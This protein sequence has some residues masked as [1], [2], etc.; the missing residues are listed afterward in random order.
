MTAPALAY[1]KAMN[2]SRD[3][4]EHQAETCHSGAAGVE[5]GSVSTDVEKS[6]CA[7]AC[8]CVCVCVGGGNYARK[9]QCIGEM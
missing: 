7:C 5:L 4:P 9:M 8:V 3:V 2:N 1:H 6:V